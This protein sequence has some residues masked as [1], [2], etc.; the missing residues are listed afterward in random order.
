MKKRKMYWRT[1]KYLKALKMKI[2][3]EFNH[4]SVMSFDELN[5]V[6]TTKETKE[7]FSRLLAFNSGEYKQIIHEARNYAL[8]YL[9]EDQK[10]KEAEVGFD[11]ADFLKLVL[12]AYN[13]VT[14]YLYE[15]EAARKR[16]RLAEEMLTA[17]E[18]RDRKRYS[19][20]LNKTAN[21][22][23]T[24]SGQY[25]I[26]LEDETV[27]EVWKNAGVKKVQWIAEL[28]GRTCHTCRDLHGQVFEIDEVPNKQHYNC[29]C[30][31]KPYKGD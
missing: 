31:I 30:T 15:K 10:K 25:A 23:Y 27:R 3:T 13:F 11:D 19:Q 20:A 2:R 6:Q 14:G 22:W 1:D 18:Y 21:L 4:L 8:G 26:S 28:D 29:R 12:S 17:R 5:V 16:L 9:D 24:Q 7:T